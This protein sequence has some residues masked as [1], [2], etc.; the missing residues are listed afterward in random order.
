MRILVRAALVL[1]LTAPGALIAVVVTDGVTPSGTIED[2]SV[3]D[4]NISINF[5]TVDVGKGGF[6]SGLDSVIVEGIEQLSSIEW[7]YRVGSTGPEFPLSAFIGDNPLDQ[8]TV[9]GGKTIVI[10]GATTFFDFTLSY[11]PFGFTPGSDMAVLDIKLNITNTDE[12]SQDITIFAFFDYD[13]DASDGGDFLD[14]ITGGPSQFSQFDDLSSADTFPTDP[15]QITG[16]VNPAGGVVAID[17]T[18]FAIETFSGILDDLEDG[19]VTDFN[20]F[21]TDELQGVNATFGYQWDVT[22]GETEGATIDVHTVFHVV[23]EPSTY[24]MLL[25]GIGSL[26]LFGR[27]GR[28]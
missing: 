18:E 9:V 20:N 13:L 23:P 28:A 4:G 16:L 5:S 22:L 26:L 10:T 8:V 2:Q 7:F 3:S 6:A 17:P 25:I 14:F 1:A 21:N 12:N 24:A 19:A 27:V 11:E 15:F